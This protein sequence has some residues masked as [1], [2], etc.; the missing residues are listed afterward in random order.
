MP[1]HLVLA[2]DV[3]ATL[4][5]MRWLAC[6]E[7]ARFPCLFDSP[8]GGP[9]GRRALLPA[10]TGASLVLW[11]DGRLEARGDGVPAPVGGFL[12]TLDGWWRDARALG[13]ARAPPAAPAGKG[14]A[15]PFAGGWCLYLAYEFAQ[16]LEPTLHLPRLPHD[17][18]LAWAG[19]T[20]A[21]VALDIDSG[22]CH[23]LAEGG[24]AH[25]IDELSAALERAAQALA[26]LP[27]PGRLPQASVDEDPPGLFTQAV[28]A[29]QEAIA[30]GDIY[31]ANLSRAW[32]LR[33]AGDAGVA[34]LYAALVQANPAPFAALARLPGGAWLLSSS[35]E[36]LVR[37]RD[38]RI[39]TRPIAGTRPRLGEQAADLPERAALLAHPKERAEHV[40]LID[41]ERN[42][43]GRVCEAGSVQ[44]DE[45]MVTE[46]YRHVHH[47][48]SNVSGR[49]R[50]GTTPGEVLR[51]V[52]PGGTITGCP[53]LRAMEVIGALEGTVRGPYTGSLGYLGVDG[54]MD[55]NILIRTA[56][57][58]GNSLGLRAGA[59]IVADSDPDREL[60]ETRAKARGVL[61][62]FGAREDA[63]TPAV[64]WQ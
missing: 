14:G 21:V 24:A 9:L 62:A 19:R 6:H 53:K 26:N 47:I 22:H 58:Q 45:F 61:Q 54:T 37:V 4:A 25:R 41:L 28:R 7:P 35:P 34:P 59:G 29:A 32:R 18:P 5:Q 10:A 55:L 31:Q 30:A 56:L 2:R 50:A 38:G 43:L 49:L 42:D 44:V 52:F 20:D 12:A 39:E 15:Q 51:A 36:R 8:S 48:V 16:Q 60:A 33:L 46:S 17:Q 27:V 64:T 63:S 40:M 13:G 23:L 11:G 57:L 1:A 3:D